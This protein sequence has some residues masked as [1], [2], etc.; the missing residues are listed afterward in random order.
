M[1]LR[2]IW[3][4]ILILLVSSCAVVN[5][6][7]KY[8][9]AS[10]VY[11]SKVFDSGSKKVYVDHSGETIKVY[12][13]Y[14][15]SK[16]FRID[17]VNYRLL[18]FGEREMDSLSVK[19]SF[20]Q[21]SFDVDVLTIPFKYRFRTNGFPRQ[22][23]TQLNGGVYFGYRSDVYVLHYNKDLL[24][25]SSRNTTHF[26]FSFGGFTGIGSTTMNPWVA[27]DQITIEYEG[28]AWSKGFAAIAGLNN[29]TAGI[30]LGWDHLLDQ[31]KRHWIY[32]GKPWV[33]LVFGLNL[34]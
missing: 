1:D 16:R 13:G 6:S 14:G 10:G 3:L 5:Q 17:S 2:I 24:G 29:F 19:P 23:T 28:V 8:N 22:F 7:P 18:S 32:Q 20:L 15:G 21:T 12:A 31:N 26:G 27:R 34:N 30:A 11:S 33:G 4:L 9:F 25:M